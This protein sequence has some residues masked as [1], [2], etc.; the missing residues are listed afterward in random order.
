MSCIDIT[1]ICRPAV[2]TF[3]GI[4]SPSQRFANR[5]RTADG[6]RRSPACSSSWSLMTRLSG[7]SASLPYPEGRTLDLLRAL[8]HLVRARPGGSGLRH[9]SRPTPNRLSVRYQAHNPYSVAHP[10][11]QPRVPTDRREVRLHLRRHGTWRLLHARSAPGL[12]GLLDPP[13]GSAIQTHHHLLT[14]LP[15]GSARWGA[16]PLSHDLVLQAPLV[17]AEYERVFEQRL[18]LLGRSRSNNHDRA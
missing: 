14:Q 15:R 6:G 11:R 8:L 12:Q 7:T 16:W 3:R 13:R 18:D 10:S 2:R 4:S 1:P 5:S 9:R 17:V